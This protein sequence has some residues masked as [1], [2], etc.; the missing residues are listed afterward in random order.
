MAEKFRPEFLNPDIKVGPL[1][2]DKYGRGGFV[3]VGNLEN[4]PDNIKEK[5]TK[6]YVIK[7]YIQSDDPFDLATTLF[8]ENSEE[9]RFLEDLRLLVLDFYNLYQLNPSENEI[10]QI[11]HANSKQ[12]F[13]DRFKDAKDLLN[14]VSIGGIAKELKQRNSIIKNYFAE[15]LP[16]LVVPTQV[17]IGRDEGSHKKTLY[18]IQPH[19]DKASTA[20]YPFSESFYKY[21]LWGVEGEKT[22]AEEVLNNFINHIKN[23]LPEKIDL[24]KREIPIF[25]KE[26]SEMLA[27][28]KYFPYDCAKLNNLIFTEH[29]LRL[30]DTNA[31]I[32]TSPEIDWIDKWYW[33]VFNGSLKILRLIESKL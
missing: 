29:G 15:S 23:T 6:G 2:D 25:I 22:K 21:Y 13:T 9:G 32:P 26:I 17:I 19:L 1:A 33:E 10:K 14:L 12:L 3:E 24:F 31:V 7:Q 27:K 8:L 11:I 4:L 28:E 30:I 20:S 5:A 18:E 16:E